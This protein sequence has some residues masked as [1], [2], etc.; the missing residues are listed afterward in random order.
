MTGQE[1]Q[2]RRLAEELC[3]LTGE[4]WLLYVFAGD[5]LS[6]RLD[7]DQKLDFAAKAVACGRELAEK[8]LLAQGPLSMEERIRACGGRLV[9]P[10]PPD[11]GLLPMFAAFTEPD[12]ISVYAGNARATDAL[13]Q[14]EGLEEL[15][16]AVPTEEVLLAHELYHLLEYQDPAIYTR[17][18]H[19]LLWRLG[20]LE[21]RS[22]ILC[23]SEIAAMAFAEAMTGLGC[24]AYVLDVLMLYVN[25]PQL[26]LEKRREIMEFVR[27]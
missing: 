9:R 13:R 10:D 6:G 24:S 1:G 20:R 25:N 18:K 3:T 8:L 7:R 23:L 26:A 5:P 11:L 12:E 2:A 14:Q 4:D 17:Q 27:R 22:S 21:N 19:L 15:I 16:G